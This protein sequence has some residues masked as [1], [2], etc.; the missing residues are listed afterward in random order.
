MT[1]FRDRDEYE[2]WKAGRLKDL[3]EK[4]GQSEGEDAEAG[5]G[6]RSKD[7][8]SASEGPGN[9]GGLAD[10]GALFKRAWE[11]Y[12][13]R[14]GVLI[15]LCILTF[16]FFA[17]AFGVCLGLGYLFSDLFHTGHKLLPATGAVAGITAGI[18]FFTWG[19]AAV[20]YAVV[21]E[22]LGV[23]GALGK[24]RS[25]IWSFMWLISLIGYII[26]GGFLLF[27][28]PGVIFS[29]WFA[30]SQFI[31]IAE[32][33]RG[34]DCLLKSK[35][36]VRGLWLEVFLRLF[37]VWIVSVLIGTVPLLGP[38]LSFLFFPYLLIFIR[39]VYD[40]VRALK[41]EVTYSAAA[42]EKLKWAGAATAGYLA[43]PLFI[44]CLM[45]T[46]IMALPF[47]ILKGCLVFR[48]H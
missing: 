45:G 7:F 33:G 10:P 17:G 1:E 23:G 11:I 41:G 20:V 47:M 12:K 8:R 31:F 15:V 19:S 42:T 43:V 14:A 48:V 5:R 24:S 27:I 21:D 9:K 35:E 26:P 34:M 16:L 28:V 36:Y 44:L 3:K 13:R 18:V 6:E 32:G 30:F 46:S 29:V 2:K 22:G 25:V 37:L 4:N 40:D 39:L 38:I